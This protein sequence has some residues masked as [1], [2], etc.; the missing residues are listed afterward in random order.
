M[1]LIE[2]QRDMRAWLVRD[3]AA[4]G[5]R[6]GADAGPG[7]RV[8]QNNYR[9]QLVACLEDSFARTRDWIGE[10]AF[11]HAIVA[12]VER[13]P[14]SSWTL[15]AYPRDFPATLALLYPDD[16]DVA[17][18][19]WIECALGE[20]FVGP[21]AP[22][23]AADGL[24]AIDWDRAVLH[25]TPTLDLGPLSTNVAVIWTALAVAEMPPAVELLPE[26]GA[27]LVWRQDLVSRFR[28]IDQIEQQALLAARAGLSFANLCEAMV[29]AHGQ[30]DGIARAGQLLGQWLADGL[31]TDVEERPL[32]R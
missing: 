18:L 23:V 9:A 12:H 10:E 20:A 3:D 27:I 14:P 31:I 32:S 25:F 28:A 22:A 13:V 21:N 24:G 1:T 6:F 15:D 5:R 11:H 19:G 26:P 2:L 7:L 4:A 17:E 8:Y 30:E 29:A 16:P